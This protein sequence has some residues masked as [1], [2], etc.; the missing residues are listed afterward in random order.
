MKNG[1][2]AVLSTLSSHHYCAMNQ[3]CKQWNIKKTAT[4]LVLNAILGYP[5]NPFHLL[6]QSFFM[7]KGSYMKNILQNN[8]V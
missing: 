4:A 8:P 7:P 2:L 6:S 5:S 3:S 1:E